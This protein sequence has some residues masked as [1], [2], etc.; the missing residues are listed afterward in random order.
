MVVPR[1]APEPQQAKKVVAGEFGLT[2]DRA[3]CSGWQVAVRVYGND[4]KPRPARPAQV[5]VAAADVDEVEAT[6]LKRPHNGPAAHQIQIGEAQI[7]VA[8]TR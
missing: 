4:D 8:G 5:V 3:Q 7:S 2:D 1:D 6:L